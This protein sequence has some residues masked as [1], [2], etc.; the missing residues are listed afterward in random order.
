[1]KKSWLTALERTL[2]SSTW[3]SAAPQ[4]AETLHISTIVSLLGLSLYTLGLGLGP[5]LAA[6]L[7][8]SY[9][10]R[11]VYLGTYPIFLLFVLGC[12][13]SSNVQSL[14]IC[15][16]FA[17][18]FAS[19]A[20][21]V[22]GGSNSDLWPS[23]YRGRVS[24]IFAMVPFAGSSLGPVISGYAV[25]NKDWK[26]SQWIILF[27]G[28]VTYL[29]ALPMKETYKKTILQHRAKR[30]NIPPPP[31][32]LPSGNQGL[33]FML[34]L[35]FLRPLHMLAT[36]PIVALTSLYSAFNFAILYSFFAAFPY[37]YKATYNFDG[38]Q[39]GLTFLS[40]FL[41]CITG[42]L[43][44]ILIDRLTYVNLLK[45]KNMTMLPQERRLIGAMIGSIALP[46]SLFWFAWSA[47]AEVHWI[48]PVLAAFPFGM[49]VVLVFVSNITSLGRVIYFSN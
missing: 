20:L 28:A 14:M 29:Y 5:V 46:I 24:S 39:T 26:W 23:L 8:E 9:G 15:R 11:V 47:R 7:S 32:R 3:S 35:T 37:V 41:G 12:G 10:R 18:V 45:Q 2:G 48:S 30:Y 27:F 42:S 22:G 40:V 19:P 49:G 16:F 1:M 43:C 38:G 17:G 36:E 44:F 21:S 13:L 25:Q 33:K 31:N 6:P 34:M 4:Y